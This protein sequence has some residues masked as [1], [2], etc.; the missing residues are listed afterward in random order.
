MTI[1][2]THELSEQL[3]WHWHAQAR[4]R[5]SGLTDT[6]YFWEPTPDAWNIRPRGTGRAPVNA[7]AGNFT[8]DFEFPQPVPAP[9]T[10]IAWRLG[11]ILV[12]VLGARNASH[13][14][15]A[16]CDYHS[17]DYSGT[18]DLALADLD[19]KYATWIAGV[20]ALSERD[21]AAACGPTEGPFGDQPMATLVLHI[22]RE[23]IH[24]L[25]E[26]ALLRDLYPDPHL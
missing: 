22:N 12:G 6:E 1:N 24:H 17:Y 7:G 4:P 9:V 25:A 21:L 19:E 11:H 18:A 3:D 16:S 15:S 5:L 26:I 2:W 10:T 23:L 8:I 14:G 20:R 13:F